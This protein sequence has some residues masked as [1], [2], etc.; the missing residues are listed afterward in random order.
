[1]PE[2]GRTPRHNYSSSFRQR[3]P[4]ILQIDIAAATSGDCT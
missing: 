3:R 1:M 2:C 4:A